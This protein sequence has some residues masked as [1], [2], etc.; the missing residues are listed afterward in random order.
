MSSGEFYNGTKK[1]CTPPACACRRTGS[2]ALSAM[3]AVE[4]EGY[5]EGTSHFGDGSL[6]YDL[7]VKLAFGMVEVRPNFGTPM[8]AMIAALSR[9][10][11]WELLDVDDVPAFRVWSSFR[12]RAADTAEYAFA[13]GGVM[14]MRVGELHDGVQYLILGDFV[15]P[16]VVLQPLDVGAR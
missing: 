5:P 10:L 6:V 8:P 16:G 9:E 7:A 11:G 4:Y 12:Y 3:T 13:V 2:G 14:V 1:N 15:S